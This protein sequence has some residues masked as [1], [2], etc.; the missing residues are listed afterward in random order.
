MTE[1]P[2]ADPAVIPPPEAAS[3]GDMGPAEEPIEEEDERR[4]RKLL[5]LLLLLLGFAILLGLAIW[6]L[7]FRQPIPLPPLPG[8]TVMPVYTTS[9]YGANRPMG[10]AAS[11]DGSRIYIG[12]TQGDRTARVFDAAGTQ[13]GL[14]EPPVSTG[15]DHVPVYLAYNALTNEVYVSDRP[16]GAIYIYDP[17]GTYQRTFDPGPAQKGWQPLGMTFDAAGNLYVTDVASNPQRVLVFDPLGAL[18]RTIG[19]TAGFNFPNGV[20]VDAAGNVYV[21]DGNNGRLVV[22]DATDTVIAQVGRGVGEGN[23]GLPRGVAIDG[24]GQVYVGDATGQG[25]FVYGTAVPGEK[26]LAFLGFFGG[27]GASNGTFQFPNGVAVDARGRLYVADSG[28]DR[29]QVWSY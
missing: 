2:G 10:V 11:P 3:P 25:V 29:V 13:L 26:S 16:T 19:T 4:K 24:R 27:Q 6:Y 20:A 17:N 14:M 21:T 22:I 28:N 8:E 23:L 15:T 5:L 1:T 18:I 9:I 12:E 7:L